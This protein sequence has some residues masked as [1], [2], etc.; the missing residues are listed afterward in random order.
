M[1]AD[2]GDLLGDS[3]VQAERPVDCLRF[4]EKLGLAHHK[5]GNIPEAI[6]TFNR[7]QKSLQAAGGILPRDSALRK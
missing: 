5:V 7:L 2:L 4:E 1:S 3:K 6:G